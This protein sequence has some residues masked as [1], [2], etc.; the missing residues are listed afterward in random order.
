[1][2]V[3]EGEGEEVEGVEGVV[4]VVGEGVE[5]GVVARVVALEGGF[6]SCGGGVSFCHASFCDDHAS[7]GRPGGQFRWR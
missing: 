5:E 1:M 7:R 2:V 3:V 4:V 6:Q